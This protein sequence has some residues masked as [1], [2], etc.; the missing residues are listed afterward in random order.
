MQSR[1]THSLFSHSH[2][3][4]PSPSFTLSKTDGPEFNLDSWFSV[5]HTL[6]LDFPNLPYLIDRSS[7]C[8]LTESLAIFRYIASISGSSTLFHG[9]PELAMYADMIALLVHEFR[10][11][12]VS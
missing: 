11:G 8:K 9:A 4:P 5:K 2:A 1:H 6:G 7:G 3:S 10:G 12:F